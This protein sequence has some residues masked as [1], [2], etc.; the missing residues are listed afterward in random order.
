MNGDRMKV[1]KSKGC[2]EQVSDSFC[3]N[4][5]TLTLKAFVCSSNQGCIL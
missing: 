5:V 4:E 1:W 2:L 3:K